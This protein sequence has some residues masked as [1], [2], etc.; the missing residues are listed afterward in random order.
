MG[1]LHAIRPPAAVFLAA[2]F[3]GPGLKAG[4]V[5]LSHL[6]CPYQVGFSHFSGLD[7]HFLGDYLNLFNSHFCI[8]P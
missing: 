2:G 1:V 3:H 6:D 8:P 4:S 7:S 5:S